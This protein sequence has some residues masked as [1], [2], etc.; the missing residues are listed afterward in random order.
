MIRMFRPQVEPLTVLAVQVL[1]RTILLD[2]E[3]LGAQAQ[4]AIELLPVS[5]AQGRHCHTM[6]DVVCMTPK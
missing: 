2:H 3:D 6:V 4:Q 5:S 1:I